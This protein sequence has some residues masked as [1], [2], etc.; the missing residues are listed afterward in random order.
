MIKIERK[1]ISQASKLMQIIE[2]Y[3]QDEGIGTSVEEFD[4]VVKNYRN[5]PKKANLI[6]LMCWFYDNPVY[7][8][9]REKLIDGTLVWELD[10]YSSNNKQGQF[11]YTAPEKISKNE[12]MKNNWLT[13]SGKKF[14]TESD[15]TEKC[16]FVIVNIEDDCVQMSVSEVRVILEI[17]EAINNEEDY[18]KEAAVCALA[19]ILSKDDRL[20]ENKRYINGTTGEKYYGF[21]SPCFDPTKLGY[22][23]FFDAEKGKMKISI[24]D[25]KK[26]KEANQEVKED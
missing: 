19:E 17:M 4:Q 16:E 7:V 20:I 22:L 10:Q 3:V 13:I 25:Y 1:N 12:A 18:N 9:Y 8:P 15:Y 14:F 21:F 23:L 6:K 2:G 5:N 24:E 26:I 11:I